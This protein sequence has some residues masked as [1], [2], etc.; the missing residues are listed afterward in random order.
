MNMSMRVKLRATIPATT[1]AVLLVACGAGHEN[2]GTSGTPGAETV[3]EQTTNRQPL[4]VRLNG[5]SRV[6]TYRI[7]PTPFSSAHFDNDPAL[8]LPVPE[9]TRSYK[10][11]LTKLAKA[12]RQPIT[13]KDTISS[14]REKLSLYRSQLLESAEHMGAA[15]G[16]L[17]ADMKTARLAQQLG[18]DPAALA[19]ELD[20]RLFVCQTSEHLPDRQTLSV[21]GLVK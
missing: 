4:S 10:S 18:H 6:P 3:S 16:Y 2:S 20:K 15:D 21:D 9:P 13:A 5:I 14:N 11:P 1:A 17:F 12:P 7:E 19:R 8:G